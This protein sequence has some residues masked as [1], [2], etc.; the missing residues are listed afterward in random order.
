MAI[1]QPIKAVKSCSDSPLG[2]VDT[3]LPR[4]LAF[5]NSCVTI[6]RILLAVNLLHK[7]S[8][9]TGVKTMPQYLLNIVEFPQ[10]GDS[11]NLNIVL[12]RV[13]K[14][15]AKSHECSNFLAKE[16]NAAC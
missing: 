7:H 14:P 6:V 3:R 10:G 9:D 5:T 12:R 1:A 16:R 4:Y 15:V 11:P 13:S 8:V 2:G